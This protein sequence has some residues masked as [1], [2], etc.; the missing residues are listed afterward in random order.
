MICKI[1]KRQKGYSIF[2]KEMHYPIGVDIKFILGIC[3][4][5]YDSIPEYIPRSQIRK[6]LERK[7]NENH[8]T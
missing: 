6:F 7:S 1:C 3:F 5:C 4:D 2:T 8:N